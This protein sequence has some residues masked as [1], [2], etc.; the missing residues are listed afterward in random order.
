[1]I[2]T[3]KRYEES[4]GEICR[5]FGQNP[6]VS[7]SMSGLNSTRRFAPMSNVYGSRGDPSRMSLVRWLPCSVSSRRQNESFLIPGAC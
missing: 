5:F 6:E 4:Y 1:M 3:L 7:H 2:T